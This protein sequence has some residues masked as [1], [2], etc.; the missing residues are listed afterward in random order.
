MVLL[1][2]AAV[3]GARPL[4]AQALRPLASTQGN[5]PAALLARGAYAEAIVAAEATLA[6]DSSN[7]GAA[8][9]LFG[10]LRDLGRLDEAVR[11]APRWRSHP[12]VA[13]A[14]A[15][16]FE[17][18]GRLGEADNLWFTAERGPDS[19]R[20]RVE[21]MRLQHDRGAPDSA[22]ARL[23]RLVN[24]VE[25]RGGARTASELHALAVASRLLGKSDPQRFKDALRYYDQALAQEPGRVE[26][27]TEL[28]ELFL[29][30][31]NAPDARATLEAVLKANPLEPRAL[32]ALV[33]LNAFEGRRSAR[34]PL[35]KLL[36]LDTANLDARVL[37]ARRLLDAE[38]H[39]EAIAEA[40]R[41]LVHDSTAPEPW[42]LIAAAR[43]MAGDTAAHRA[44]LERA[45][46]RLSGSAAAEVMLADVASRNRLYREAARFAQAGVARDARDAR[47]LGLLGINQLRIG[48]ITEGRA[49]LDRAFRMDPYDVMV[50]N[51]LDLLD[52]FGGMTTVKTAHFHLVI[53]KADADLE[54]LYVA[55]LAEEAYAA[56][57]ARYGYAP[58]A[59][60]RAEF[61]RS[62]AD[63]SVRAVGLAGLGALGVA[64]GNVV[65]L[66]APPARKPGEF[67]WGSV[68]WHEFGHVI[69]LGMTDNRVPRWVSEGLSVYE[70]RRARPGW[71]GS[72]TPTLIAAYEARRLQPVSRLNDGFVH[73][74]YGEEVILSYALSAY[75]F[76]MLEERQGIAGLRT[77]LAGYR[78]GR[79]TPELMQRVYSLDATALDA[80]FDRWF[81]AKF[82]REFAAVAPVVKVGA[83]GDTIVEVGGPLRVALEAGA[84]ALSQ[85]RW[86]E[87][88]RAG[89]QAVALF[90]SHTEQGSGW[91]FLLAAHTARGNRAGQ[92]AALIGITARD[93]DAVD[94]N[95]ALAGLLEA[96]GDSAG[97]VA[98]LER[99]AWI[100][101]FNAKLQLR[102][103]EAAMRRRQYTAA[104][105]AR[106]AVV[107]LAPA[108]R[109]EALFRL[110]EACAA[111]GDTTAARREVL[112]ALDLAP[113][114]E[115]AQDLLL[116]LR[117]AR[118]A[119]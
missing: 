79:A 61:Y 118:K 35:G 85:K 106:R 34:D 26:A 103:A 48:Q 76:E 105:R 6:A 20:A 44:A 18:L 100:T 37:G 90:P 97:A 91:H 96:S 3:A 25:G 23:A 70:E 98:A 87:V 65:A 113:N 99:A 43:F 52:T 64:F 63:F 22:L 59:P 108:D 8:M 30:K 110:A 54:A 16:I 32:A 47:A 81:R 57:S 102:L 75:V 72:V 10:A 109:A 95:I 39:D 94:E 68:F 28:G 36:A 107:A 4:L 33:R 82:A 15:P 114:F 86:D 2:V 50:K 84:R 41:G 101:P 88:V 1:A 62:H 93:P 46:R 12:V 45:H 69:T 66:D 73:P 27:R 40:R 71:G 119:P 24:G 104:V 29:E 56:L 17:S 80:A 13:L 19:L 115:A 58:S 14:L 5:S 31:F 77:L 67:H 21:R 89:E 9:A 51:T 117:P 7:V 116:S 42:V 49:A 92:V 11:R 83:E 78:D 111:G 53:E 112:R 74:R 38:R 55:P 60:V